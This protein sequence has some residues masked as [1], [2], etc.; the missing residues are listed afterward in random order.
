MS[1]S[2]S[3]KKLYKEMV[4]ALAAK[5]IEV[6]SDDRTARG[7]R[8]HVKFEDY[9]ATVFT[10]GITGDPR[11]KKNVIM[12][13]RQAL[14]ARGAVF[15][16]EEAEHVEEGEPQMQKQKKKYVVLSQTQRAEVYALHK[17]GAAS[18]AELCELFNVARNTIHNIIAEGKSGKYDSLLSPHAEPEPVPSMPSPP[19]TAP[20][21]RERLSPFDPRYLELASRAI[22]LK[23]N[24]EALQRDAQAFGLKVTFVLDVDWEN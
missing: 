24:L 16:H 21:A 4:E 14:R 3:S 6:L 17:T 20:P 11:S 10:G 15:S 13:A 5:G 22:D 7:H 9:E 8:L 23:K 2:L 1:T 12:H 18:T 19:P